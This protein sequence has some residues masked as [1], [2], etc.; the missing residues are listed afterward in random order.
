MDA[1]ASSDG[2]GNGQRAPGTD[3]V[4]FGKYKGEPVERLVADTDYCEWL[5]SQAWFR[6]RYARIYQLVVNYGAEPQDS[7]EHNEMQAR[8]LDEKWCRALMVVL[9]PKCRA[10]FDVEAAMNKARSNEKIGKALAKGRATT[11]VGD[12]SGIKAAMVGE[13]SFEVE[14]WDVVIEGMRSAHVRV[15]E[16]T[17]TIRRRPVLEYPMDTY[18]WRD[19]G[20]Y[21]DNGKKAVGDLEYK[22][23]G[24]YHVNGHRVDVSAYRPFDRKSGGYRESGWRHKDG[25]PVTEHWW[26]A[27]TGDYYCDRTGR[28]VLKYLDR[29]HYDEVG[30]KVKHRKGAWLDEDGQTV[31]RDQEAGYLSDP[32]DFD[33][34]HKVEPGPDSLT[35]TDCG[36]I[37]RKDHVN[38]TEGHGVFKRYRHI[39][40]EGQDGIYDHWSL[41]HQ[42]ESG[43]DMRHVLVECKPDLGDDYPTVL[44]Q[45][46]RQSTRTRHGS[47]GYRDTYT[48]GGTKVVVVR[49]ARFESVTWEQVQSIFDRA[50]FEIITEAEITAVAAELDL[51][52]QD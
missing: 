12:Y 48:I 38:D 43:P 41:L 37:R 35:L 52:N 28:R 27:E 26:N 23:R 13:V 42:Y 29:G 4:P 15:L 9:D 18:I 14:G 17:T 22:D 47:Y 34:W 19:E 11:V 49:R 21:D 25:R 2:G 16:T 44:R 20:Y 5:G 45:V 33:N 36:C 46:Q 40:H 39:N 8:F 6:E 51:E 10:S 24:W 30:S 3:I 7:P 50:G 1:F 32:S 31:W